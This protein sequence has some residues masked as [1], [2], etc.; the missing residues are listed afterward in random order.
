MPPTIEELSRWQLHY[1]YN[2]S[3]LTAIDND[4][5]T[6]EGEQLCIIKLKPCF[7]NAVSSEMS[8]LVF[9]ILITFKI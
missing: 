1:Y 2:P 5:E 7:A 8:G 6:T 4:R 9:L 3:T